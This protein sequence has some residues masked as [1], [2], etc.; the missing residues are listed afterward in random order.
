MK[1]D[2]NFDELGRSYATG[3][4]KNAVARVCIKDASG[5]IVIKPDGVLIKPIRR[6]SVLSI[7]MPVKDGASESSEVVPCW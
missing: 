3:K 2:K 1:I 7:E 5:K 4:R 6:I